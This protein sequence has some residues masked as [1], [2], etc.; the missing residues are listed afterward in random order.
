MSY[1]NTHVLFLNPSVQ[2]I[3]CNVVQS[4]KIVLRTSLKAK[5]NFNKFSLACVF[6]CMRTGATVDNLHILAIL[7]LP[8]VEC[9]HFS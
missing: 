5:G 9:L 1:V 4:S 8:Y 2:V 7:G 6:A 3:A